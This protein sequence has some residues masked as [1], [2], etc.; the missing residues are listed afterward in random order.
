MFGSL[1]I[2]RTQSTKLKTRIAR[3]VA[4][5]RTLDS[6]QIDSSA[7]REISFPLDPTNTG[8]MKGCIEACN[9]LRACVP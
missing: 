9:A 8:H 1:A 2:A 4:Y 6:K 7:D 3:T 5:L